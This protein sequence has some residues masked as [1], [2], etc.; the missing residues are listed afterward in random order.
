MKR[1]FRFPALAGLLCLLMT[2]LSWSQT[3]QLTAPRLP[4]LVI[5]NNGRIAQIARRQA[6]FNASR[7]APSAAAHPRAWYYWRAFQQAQ[8]LRE[9]QRRQ[10]GSAPSPLSVT[11]TPLGP[12]PQTD[13]GLGAVSGRVTDIQVDSSDSSGNTVYVGTAFGGVWKSTNALS[14]SPTFTPLPNMPTLAVGCIALD[15]STSPT[16][17]YV[18][19]GEPNLSGDSYYGIGILKS[20]DGGNTWTTVTGDVYG[21]QF[22]GLTWSRILVN[23]TN[24][25]LIVAASSIAGDYFNDSSAFDLS[26]NALGIFVSDDGGQT[27]VPKLNGA[28]ITDLAYDPSTRMYYAA[29]MAN[30]I[31]SS[32]DGYSWNLAHSPFSNPEVQPSGSTFIRASL[33]VRNGVLTALIANA[34]GQLSAP[35]PC[36][37]TVVTNCDTGLV[38]SSDDGKTWTPIAVPPSQDGA[39]ADSLFCDGPGECQGTYDMYVAMPPGGNDLIIGGIDVYH[40]TT[41]NGLST[42]WTNVTQSYNNGTVHPDQH[43]FAMAGGNWLIGND[44]GM[45]STANQG[46]A[47]TDLNGTLAT[48]QFISASADLGQAGIYFGGSQDNGTALM[49]AAGNPDWNLILGGDGGFTWDNPAQTSNYF[50]ENSGLSLWSSTD[51]GQ[52]FTPVVDNN[53]TTD[54]TEFYV[55]YAFSPD[56]S[57]AYVVTDRVWSGPAQPGTPDQGWTALTANLGGTATDP[58]GNSYDVPLSAIAV[59]PSDPKTIYVGSPLT[60]LSYSHDGGATWTTSNAF[61]SPTFVSSIAVSPTD[62]NTA[63]ITSQAFAPA[64]GNVFVT[65]D[66]GKT[67]DQLNTDLPTVPVNSV[68][69]DPNQ[70]QNVFI[71]TDT[72]VFAYTD[73]GPS[74]S[75]SWT[76]LGTLPAVAVLQVKVIS[77]N[78]QSTLLAATHGRGAW[79]APATA[80]PAFSLS[81][82]SSSVQVL[83]NAPSFQFTVHVNAFNGDSAPVTLQCQSLY[84]ATCSFS[85]ATAAPGSDVTVTVTPTWPNFNNSYIG[86]GGIQLSGTDGTLGYNL[87]VPLLVQGFNFGFPSGTFP[88]TNLDVEYGGSVTTTNL[89]L[90]SQTGWPQPV[91]FAITPATAGFNCTFSPASVASLAAN[92]TVNVTATCSADANA[93]IPSPLNVELQATSGP[94]TQQQ[95]YNF[96]LAHFTLNVSP[97]QQNLILASNGVAT[98]VSATSLTN[99]SG[100]ITLS[101]LN[102]PVQCS[103]SSNSIQVGQSA[104]LTFTA[105]ITA[106]TFSSTTVSIKGVSGSDQAYTNDDITLQNEQL[107]V[108]SPSGQYSLIGADSTTQT[109]GYNSL[110]YSGTLATACT[111]DSGAQCSLSQPSI[112]GNGLLTL[113][114]T[115]L[116]GLPVGAV[117]KGTVTGSNSDMQ[118]T[119]PFSVTIYDVS[120]SLQQNPI[121]LYPGQTSAGG[122]AHMETIATGSPYFLPP[123]PSYACEADAPGPCTMAAQGQFSV[124]LSALLNNTGTLPVTFHVDGTVTQGSTSVTRSTLVTVQN[125]D[126]VVTGPSAPVT[127]KAGAS[128]FFTV[129]TSDPL[130]TGYP[131]WPGLINVTCTGAPTGATCSGG[132][133][134]VGEPFAVSV[135]TTAPGRASGG[136]KQAAMAASFSSGNPTSRHPMLALLGLLWLLLLGFLLWPRRW[137]RWAAPATLAILLAL[138]VACGGG[139]SFSGSSSGP[140]PPP[141][142]PPPPA[143]TAAGTY[144]LKVTATY[145]DP[146]APIQP[147]TLSHSI[148]VTLTVQ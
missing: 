48:I 88:N 85:P 126:F 69:V 92:A 90:T 41:I 130:A 40:A 102:S 6:W 33:A 148:D 89:Q 73:L 28:P 100:P 59:A 72:G 105:P 30:G 60:G 71:G 17:I 107:Y 70:P 47:W 77:Q 13:P 38:Q 43:A 29:A 131:N 112:T 68:A 52:T 80:P 122:W 8:R 140:P 91:T 34:N 79:T 132:V 44:G 22:Y 20:T 134:L 16:T 128:T 36:S 32:S 57:T 114:L 42:T 97:A 139:S 12:Q 99:F 81:G 63:Y 62:P 125:A 96:T 35:N 1:T 104:T 54:P 51:A 25:A 75:T 129:Q 101:C 67:L 137:P 111:V 46:G 21:D 58:A 4:H 123:N 82:P 27:F 53:L 45:W 84:D 18:G 116:S 136:G 145:T 56:G 10:Y 120:V 146:S 103:F 86:P 15:P 87:T 7:Q 118:R 94:L 61:Q 64:W 26:P 65:R 106:S 141:P 11:W 113:T 127:V 115:G 2:G 9:L 19:T 74:G 49:Q 55:P 135:T 117:V 142:P 23:P 98:T 14:S 109:V 37:A 95:S 147:A 78:G 39:A 24:P 3:L 143:G 133:T 121:E 138:S 5:P 93:T 108:S 66:G 76:Q 50:T 144:T 124:D 110:N 119:T 31:F 83:Q